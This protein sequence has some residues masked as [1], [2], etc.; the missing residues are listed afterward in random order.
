MATTEPN[1]STLDN[2]LQAILATI[3]KE[4]NQ[5]LPPSV[6]SV[7]FNTV[8]SFLITSLS[9]QY[10]KNQETI[11]VLDPF[12]ST[13]MIPATNGFVQLPEDYRG[14]LGGPMIF[15]NPESDGQCK[16]IE[17]L[18]PQNF[19]TG[20]LK[21]GC[22]LQSV[23]I[24]DQSEFADLT[25]S[26]YNKPTYEQPVAF[27]TGKKQLRVCP[28]DISKCFI[29]Y[30]RNEPTFLY[31]YFTNPDDTYL[32]KKEGSIESIWGSNAFPYLYRGVLA[33]YG[34]YSS[35]QNIS[36]FSRVLNEAGIL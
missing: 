9:K 17:P 36:N 27:F 11:D 23:L 34:A 25:T 7:M 12:I 8:T 4:A 18:T 31:S 3:N 16:D 2:V 19:T 1:K 5:D 10:P 13:I 33:L 22:R 29:M 20:M 24:I 14:L 15:A 26:T 30:V 28:Y 6:F 21:G 35:D 32:F